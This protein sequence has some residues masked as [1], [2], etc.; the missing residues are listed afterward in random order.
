MSGELHFADLCRAP[1]HLRGQQ[2]L[3]QHG[4]VAE[5]L[6][7]AWTTLSRTNGPPMIKESMI[8]TI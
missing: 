1:A 7:T 4:V 2:L 3:A 5:S 6:S 8:K